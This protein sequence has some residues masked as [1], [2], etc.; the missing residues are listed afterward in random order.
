MVGTVWIGQSLMIP[1]VHKGLIQRMRWLSLPSLDPEDGYFLQTRFAYM[2][3]A[4]LGYGKFL[5]LAPWFSM[6]VSRGL[7]L[8][9]VLGK[10]K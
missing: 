3:H 5:D 9:T 4:V 6:L 2:L 10:P 8:T 7:Y 1:D